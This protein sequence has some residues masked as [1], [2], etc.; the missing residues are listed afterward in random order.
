LFFPLQR[1][2]V[3]MGKARELRVVAGMRAYSL[4]LRERIVRAVDSGQS[5]REAARR[6]GVGVSSVKRYLQ[7]RQHR[8]SLQRRPIPGGQRRIGREQEAVLWAR[9][10]AEPEAT[11]VEHCAWWE[12]AHGPRVSV[13]TMARAIARLGW[14]RKKGRWVPPS[15]TKRRGSSGGRP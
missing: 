9:L 6:F 14:T 15:A 10:E 2:S 8:G 11:L 5:Q 4:D 1:F 3:R 7:Q 13:A 12:Q